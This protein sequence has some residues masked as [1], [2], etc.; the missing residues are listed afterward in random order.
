MGGC[1]G[2]SGIWGCWS[3][4]G[5]E[6]ELHSSEDHILSIRHDKAKVSTGAATVSGGNGAGIGVNFFGKQFDG[7]VVGCSDD[8]GEH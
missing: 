1:I 6:L 2:A 7:R 4:V 3:G 5:G 8:S